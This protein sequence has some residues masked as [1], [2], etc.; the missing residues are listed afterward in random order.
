MVKVVAFPYKD[1]DSLK[2]EESR[3]TT[4]AV[5]VTA[6]RRRINRIRVASK[7]DRKSEARLG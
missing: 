3:R 1:A 6:K 4:M 5:H 2:E 7:P